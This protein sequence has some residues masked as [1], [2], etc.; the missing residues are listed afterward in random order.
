MTTYHQAKATS[1]EYMIVLLASRNLTDW[2]NC[3]DISTFVKG[4]N[5]VL[6]FWKMIRALVF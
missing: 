4:S 3:H 1:R 2:L 6:D 5:R